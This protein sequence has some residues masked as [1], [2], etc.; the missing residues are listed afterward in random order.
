MCECY[1]QGNE[2]SDKTVNNGGKTGKSSA[3]HYSVRIN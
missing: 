3:N 2:D 1:L